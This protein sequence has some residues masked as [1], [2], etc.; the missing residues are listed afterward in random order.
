MKSEENKQGGVR[1]ADASLSHVE[2]IVLAGFGGDSIVDGPGLRCVLF[3]QGC[4]HHCPGCHNP[5]THP[6]E[7]GTAYTAEEL[8]A[9]IHV[10]PLSRAVTF[11]GGEPFSQAEALLPLAE[12]LR[13]KGYGLA[14]YSG[15]TFEELLAGTAGQRELLALLDTLVDG[16]YERERRSLTLRFRGSENQRILDVQRSLAAGQALWTEDTRWTGENK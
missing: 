2:T 10:H 6:F 14:A 8:L 5:A 1:K 13:E 4:P 11:S 9:K 15:Y 16:R 12:K 7:G 3:C